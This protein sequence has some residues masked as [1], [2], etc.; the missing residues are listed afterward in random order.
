MATSVVK[1]QLH[2]VEA[3]YVLGLSTI[4]Y[5]FYPVH[6]TIS[7]GHVVSSMLST[8]FWCGSLARQQSVVMWT[9][10]VRR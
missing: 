6:C 3:H 8:S 5:A 7:Y 1:A 4:S 9:G 10:G 2:A